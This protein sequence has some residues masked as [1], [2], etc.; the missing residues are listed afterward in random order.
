MTKKNRGAFT[1]FNEVD[2]DSVCVYRAMLHCCYS[3]PQGKNTLSDEEAYIRANDS[4][5][6][7]AGPAGLLLPPGYE[8]V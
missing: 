5:C 7:R 4:C 2:S 3:N 8:N 1:I 6:A